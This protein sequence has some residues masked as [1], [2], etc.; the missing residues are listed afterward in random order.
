MYAALMRCTLHHIDK[1][2]GAQ[3][4]IKVKIKIKLSEFITQKNK[5]LTH[6][7]I[8]SKTIFPIVSIPR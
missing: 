4:R 5:M 3:F 2:F 6:I 8:S 1:I 7:R